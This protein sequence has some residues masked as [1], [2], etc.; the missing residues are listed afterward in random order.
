GDD[1]RRKEDIPDD[2]F[3]QS[4]MKVLR[5]LFDKDAPDPDEILRTNWGKDEF[6]YG[7]YSHIPPGAESEDYDAIAEPVNDV[8]FF[9]GEGTSSEYPGT[10]H[11]ALI[12]GRRAAEEILDL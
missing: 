5:K 6:S 3:V 8:L 11:G 2:K 9:A 12:S 7:S 10:I 1:A 4:A